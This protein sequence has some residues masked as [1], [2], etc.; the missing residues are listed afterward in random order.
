MRH[1]VSLRIHVNHSWTTFLQCVIKLSSLG[2]KSKTLWHPIVYLHVRV[3]ELGSLDKVFY[4]YRIELGDPESWMS[5]HTYLIDSIW[6]PEGQFSVPT[7]WTWSAKSTKIQHHWFILKMTASGLWRKWGN[8]TFAEDLSDWSPEGDWCVLE[9]CLRECDWAL[10]ISQI[11]AVST[12]QETRLLWSN[13]SLLLKTGSLFRKLC[14]IY[15]SRQKKSKSRLKFCSP[16]LQN[17]NKAHK[18]Q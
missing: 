11:S 3:T 1:Q 6:N 13:S 8:K 15:G 16:E 2:T 9:T 10:A 14:T 5:W 7:N 12:G 18:F 17:L 4:Y